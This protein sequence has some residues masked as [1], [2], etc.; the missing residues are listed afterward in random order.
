MK[1]S[2]R[3]KTL[4][5]QK[6]PAAKQAAQNKTS[7]QEPASPKKAQRAKYCTWR[8]LY[9]EEE[10]GPAS[11][12]KAQRSKRSDDESASAQTPK[13]L[14]GEGPPISDSDVGDEETS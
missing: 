5:A 7:E 14:M 12:K 10:E 8:G 9:G 4:A 11:P 6:R 2:H 3:L 13:Q 1:A